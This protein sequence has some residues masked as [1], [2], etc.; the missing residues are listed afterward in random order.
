MS[1]SVSARSWTC[2]WPL[3]VWDG[4]GL[5]LTM[6]RLNGGQFT[7]PKRICAA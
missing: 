1:R 4:A 2:W 7:W 6:K 3:L 5:V